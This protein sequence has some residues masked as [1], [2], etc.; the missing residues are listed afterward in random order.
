MQ[1]REPLQFYSE[2]LPGVDTSELKGR[3]IV[4]EGPEPDTESTEAPMTKRT[5][6]L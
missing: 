5:S 4:I 2:P 3:L 1:T 6:N